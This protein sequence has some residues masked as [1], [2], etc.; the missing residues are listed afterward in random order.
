MASAHFDGNGVNHA[1]AKNPLS[2]TRCPVTVA[3]TYAK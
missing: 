2:T 3:F 1:M